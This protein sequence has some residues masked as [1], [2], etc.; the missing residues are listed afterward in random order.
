MQLQA[1]PTWQLETVEHILGEAP[2][3]FYKREV[4]V[5]GEEAKAIDTSDPCLACSLVDFVVLPTGEQ[6]LLEYKCPYKAVK[7]NLTPK[8]AAAKYKDF[9]S[10]LNSSGQQELKQKHAYF[11]QV[12]GSL[13]VTGKEWCQFVL[14]TP[15]GLHLQVPIC[16]LDTKK[17]TPTNNPS[18]SLLLE[19]CLPPNHRVLPTRCP[20]RACPSPL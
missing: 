1:G 19:T 15:K 17:L 3:K 8:Q 20:F 5:T 4:L 13:A 10:V 7:E 11:Y 14:W 6:G 12:Q 16:A 9:C 18:R 2:G